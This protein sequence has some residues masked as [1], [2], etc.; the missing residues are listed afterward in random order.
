MAKLTEK[1]IGSIKDKIIGTQMAPKESVAPTSLSPKHLKIISKNFMSISPM[2]RDLNVASQNI[3]ELVRVMGGKPSDKEDKVAGSGLTEEEREKKLESLVEKERESESLKPSK[4]E[5][6]KSFFEKM[7]NKSVDKLKKTSIGKKAIELKKQFTDNKFIKGFQK[8]FKIAAIVG[9]LFYSFK[10]TITEWVKGLFATIKEKFDEFVGEIKEWFNN[11]VTKIV[12]GVRGFVDGMIEKVS[13]FFEKIGDWFV[14]KFQFIKDT[15]EPVMTFVSKVWDKFNKLIDGFKDRIRPIVKGALD[16]SGKDGRITKAIKGIGLDKFLGLS[17]PT[18]KDKQVKTDVENNQKKRQ[19]ERDVVEAE[20]TAKV[21]KQEKEKQYTGDDEIVRKRLGIGEK[22]K[23]M[24][25]EEAEKSTV[26]T[27]AQQ[28]NP[29]P[30]RKETPTISSAEPAQQRTTQ[31]EKSVTTGKDQVKPEQESKSVAPSPSKKE[32]APSGVPTG[33][34]LVK[35]ISPEQGKKAMLDEMDRQNITDPTIR[36]AIMAQAAKETGG[37]QFLSENLGYRPEGLKRTFG[38]LRNTP[39]DVIQNAVKGGAAAIGELIYGGS[40]D[41]PSYEF[42]VRNLGNTQP[43]D[44]AKYRGRG[45]FQLTGRANY[46][47]AGA[48]DRPEKLLNLDEAAKTAVDF[49][50]RYKGDFGDPKAFTKY[51]NGGSIGLDERTKYFQ[52]FLQDPSITKPGVSGSTTPTSSGG[53]TASAAPIS[54]SSSPSPSSGGEQSTSASSAPS[55][56][57]SVATTQSGVDLSGFHPE[58]EKRVAAMAADF[59][60]KTGKKLLITSGYRSNE[61]QKQLWDKKVAEL[62]GNEA[63]ARKLVA[64]PMAPLGKGKGSLHL[65]GLAI[66]INSKGPN[67]INVLAG[68]RTSSTGWLESFGL[69]R[70][71]ANEDW[72]IQPTGSLPTPDNPVNPGAPTL[73]ADKDGKAMDVNSGKKETIGAP[74]TPPSGDSGSQIA[75][76]SNDLASGQRQ[77][78]KPSTPVVVNAP[79]TNT[80]IVNNRQVVSAPQQKTNVIQSLIVRVA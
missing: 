48:D 23:T 44:G 58:F 17:D 54:S 3:K 22:T 35:K 5:K 34:P 62:G 57:K 43:G 41:S 24:R 45:F 26:P 11:V 71:I 25:K 6:S 46:K 56:I 76:A 61:K 15:F 52:Q 60:S 32:E 7:K 74:T 51:V 1:L 18:T 28:S 55:S 50:M 75:A 37:F 16:F 2:A 67:G 73:V 12:D 20:E 64:E 78:Q 27:P 14:E 63:A 38:R 4:T 10:D 13:D 33:E 53:A 36:A 40:K 79:T 69:S 39:I 59:E 30:T 9:I 29:V 47:R 31:N 19:V 72:H 80:T 42:G 68:S 70:P 66:D 21:R 8:Y 49:A 65:K 77:Q